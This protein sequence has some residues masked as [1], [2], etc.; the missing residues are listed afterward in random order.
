[1]KCSSCGQSN[2]SWARRCDHCGAPIRQ[3]TPS[4]AALQ[5]PKDAEDPVVLNRFVDRRDCNCFSY[6]DRSVLTATAFH[7]DVQDEQGDGW[8]R[9]LDLIEIA[10]ADGREEFAP[11]N[12]MTLKARS[13]VITLPATIG[14]LKAVRSLMLY[15]SCL[16]RIPPEIGEMENLEKFTPY[17]SGRLHWFPYE[18]TRCTVL[19]E[20]TV[21]TR[22]L[23]GNYKHR[24]PFPELAAPLASTAGLDLEHLPPARYGAT[25]ISS[26]SICRTPLAKTGLHQVWIS[27]NVGTDVLPLLVNACSP[28]CVARVPPAHTG[29]VPGTHRGGPSVVQPPE[30]DG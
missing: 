25:S 2:F 6:G 16:V 11:F 12:E 13:E 28:E 21:S 27:L 9:L 29:Y 1:M 18:I 26:C 23:Y 17:T 15:G 8:K 10:A 7:A 20:S 19:V 3:I 4:P 14:K 30:R 24:P 22:A 5:S